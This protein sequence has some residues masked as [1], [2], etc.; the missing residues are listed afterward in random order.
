MPQYSRPTNSCTNASL[1]T[2]RTPGVYDDL[3]AAECVSFLNG[4]PPASADLIVAAEVFP[5]LRSLSDVTAAAQAVL[6]PGG[7]FRFS[8]EACRLRTHAYV[9]VPMS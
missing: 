9:T 1:A 2:Q 5:Y 6:C 4:R 3:V 8:T 7:V